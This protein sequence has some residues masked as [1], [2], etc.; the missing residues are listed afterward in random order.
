MG[1]QPVTRP[2]HTKNNT[3][4]EQTHTD[5]HASSGTRIHDSNVE[6]AKTVHTLDRVAT[7]IG[8]IPDNLY[9]RTRL[10]NIWE[11]TAI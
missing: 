8:I 7:V 3:N 6:R 11:D 9:K 2:L 5:I 10:L 1:D 4:T